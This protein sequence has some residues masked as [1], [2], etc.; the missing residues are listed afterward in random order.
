M[1]QVPWA[2]LAGTQTALGSS[3]CCWADATWDKV[4]PYD[5]TQFTGHLVPEACTLSRLSH[6]SEFPLFKEVKFILKPSGNGQT[7]YP[8][9]SGER[10]VSF[11][12]VSIAPLC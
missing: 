2:C 3:G 8:Y 7:P 10:G 5:A 12:K 1:Y 6:S 11:S 4:L 9:K